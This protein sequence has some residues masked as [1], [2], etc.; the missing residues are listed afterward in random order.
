MTDYLDNTAE[1]VLNFD[2]ETLMYKLK[3]KTYRKFHKTRKYF[4]IITE[5]VDILIKM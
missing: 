1:L 4:L 5:N 2:E 3:N